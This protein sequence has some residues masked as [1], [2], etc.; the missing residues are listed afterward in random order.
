[1]TFTKFNWNQKY[2]SISLYCLGVIILS[3]L[4]IVFVFKFDS[5]AAGF[6]WVGKVS[7]PIICGIA[8]AYILNPL[9]KWVE[10]KFFHKL[11]DDKP[12]KRGIVM[13]NLRRSPVGESKIVK[14]ID[15]HSAKPEKKLRRRKA[16]ARA[17]S[18]LIAYLFVLVLL[19]GLGY[20]VVP[21]VAKSVVDLAD[22]MPTYISRAEE[23][24]EETFANNPDLAKY[25]AGE[26]DDLA[27][28]LNKVVNEIKPMA[29][30]IIGNVG[31]GIFRFANAVFVA[32]KNVLLGFIIAIY[33]LYSKERLLAQV[34]KIFFAFFKEERCRAIFSA[35]SKSNNIFKQ[36]IISNLTDAMIIFLCMLMITLAMGTPYP[37]LI[38]VVCGVTNLIP[39]FGPFIGAI[40]SAV[41]ILLVDPIKVV[42]FAIAVLILQQIDGNVIKPLMFG[43]TM[44]LPAIW[45][46]VSIVVGGGMFGIP[47]MLLGAPVFAV[48]Y[49][50]F[51]EF[52]SAKLEKKNLPTETD[53]Y[54]DTIEKF[55]E[56]HLAPKPAPEEQ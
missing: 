42:W 29:T 12:P 1:M 28:L 6:S 37:M 50:L 27:D 21:S 51:A 44:G 40:P 26:F 43:E 46:L 35:A 20:A 7:A 17:L 49:L 22:Q 53:D 13:R 10:D 2:T 19:A 56:E 9:V 45:V 3:V 33:L 48:F 15:K 54:T 36:Y 18:I 24:L 16:M 25:I 41:L 4:F 32:L 11:R 31:T 30:D 34:K 5:F 8:I 39:F 47:G 14:S 55:S 38:S 23:W 52:I